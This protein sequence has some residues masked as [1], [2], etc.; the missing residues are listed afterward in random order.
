MADGSG[1]RWA[2]TKEADSAERLD[3]KS[4][5]ICAT[6]LLTIGLVA[7]ASSLVV[8]VQA[9]A[10]TQPNIVMIIADDLGWKDVG[11]NGSEIRTPHID[12]L[13]ESGVRLDRFYATPACSST[14]ASLMTGQSTARTRVRSAILQ[15]SSA[16]LPLGLKI[17]PEFLRDAGYQTALVGKW[18]LG[19]ARRELPTDGK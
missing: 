10:P 18:H 2:C 5:R 9:A 17:L 16:S 11:H 19:H 3:T 14:R 13:A 8:P 6:R 12:R 4:T 1:W 7:L 15:T